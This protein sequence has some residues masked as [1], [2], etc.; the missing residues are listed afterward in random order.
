MITILGGTCWVPIAVFSI[1]K[2]IANRKKLVNAYSPS[3]LSYLLLHSVLFPF[4]IYLLSQAVGDTSCQRTE[5]L[6]LE[7]YLM[8]LLSSSVRILSCVIATISESPEV[9][10]IVMTSLNETVLGVLFMHLL[11]M[12]Y[13]EEFCHHI[14]SSLRSDLHEMTL[15][16][17]RLMSTIHVSK[18]LQQTK[19]DLLVK[20][21]YQ[22]EYATTEPGLTVDAVSEAAGECE[23]L[24][25][26]STRRV[27]QLLLAL[28]D[29]VQVMSPD[30]PGLVQTSL[31]FGTLLLEDT[32]LCMAHSVRSSITTQKQW[33]VSQVQAAVALA[34]GASEVAGDYP[35]WS[36]NPHSVVKDTILKAYQELFGL[37]AKVDAVHAGIECGLFADS[38]EGLD[39]VSIGPELADVHTPKEKLS[40][41]SVQ[42]T[43]Q[44]MQAVLKASGP[45]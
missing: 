41:P 17:C 22:K 37:E 3:A 8:Q 9:Q 44:L 2:T 29:G 21:V 40:I 6:I 18:S 16:W 7:G 26:D 23:V 31:N 10:A 45:A 25:A 4:Q 30:M 33:I 27:R 28:P 24:T 14:A 13:L 36:Y 5:S 1:E 39:C 15:L 11:S 38:I 43:Y 19:D 32:Q 20:S 35:G 34:G 42:R 12:L